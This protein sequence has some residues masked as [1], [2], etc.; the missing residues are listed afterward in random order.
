MNSAEPSVS[1]MLVSATDLYAIK[2]RWFEDA[3]APFV[4]SF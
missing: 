2:G 1:A 4:Q 3:A